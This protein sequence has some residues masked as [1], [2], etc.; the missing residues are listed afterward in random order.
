MCKKNKNL[1]LFLFLSVMSLF[2]K[3]FILENQI[4]DFLDLIYGIPFDFLIPSLSS[5]SFF[6]KKKF[7]FWEY[8]F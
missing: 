8:K 4:W 3:I 7:S 6:F 2:S 5:P 1:L